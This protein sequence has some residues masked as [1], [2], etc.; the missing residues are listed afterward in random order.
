M[1][2]QKNKNNSIT[3]KKEIIKVKDLEGYL[4]DLNTGKIKKDLS[5]GYYTRL[6]GKYD[7]YLKNTINKYGILNSSKIF[8]F[9]NKKERNKLEDKLFDLLD[10]EEKIP[11]ILKIIYERICEDYI[12][13]IYGPRSSYNDFYSYFNKQ[14]KTK[15]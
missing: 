4:T 14:N 11:S 1:K 3:Q 5:F 6:F 15:N 9:I 7:S 13:A 12:K 2:T 8:E 10:L